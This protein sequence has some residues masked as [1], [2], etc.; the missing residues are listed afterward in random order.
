MAGATS[1]IGQTERVE[2]VKGIPFFIRRPRGL[3]FT[4]PCVHAAQTDW[5]KD[6]RH[7]L[8]LAEKLRFQ[9]QFRHVLQH[10]LAQGDISQIGG[11]A[12]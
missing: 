5:P 1:S 3:H 12:P 4:T 6:N 8:R 10:T 9:T 2:R 11:I 7:C